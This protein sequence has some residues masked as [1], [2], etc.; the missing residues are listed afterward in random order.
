MKNNFQIDNLDHMILD[1]ITIDARIPF[2]EVA[3]KCNISGA[4]V[5]QRVQKLVDAGIISG[6]GFH[7]SPKGLGYITCA[8]IGLQVN[9]IST[10]TH[11]NVFNKISEIPEIVECHHITGRYSLLLKI[12]A[13]SNEHL[14][15]LIVEKI[16]S[17]PEIVSTET[18]ISL[19]E[20]FTRTLPVK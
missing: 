4:A 16:Q 15:Q 6:S 3:R 14:K 1:L 13:R 12:F 10:S 5:H 9:L 19:E 18:Y 11:D 8:F 2:L 20:G 7:L 17:I